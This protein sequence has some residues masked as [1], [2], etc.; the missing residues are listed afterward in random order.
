MVLLGETRNINDKSTYLIKINIKV[1]SVKHLLI[2]IHPKIMSL[3]GKVPRNK[4]PMPE[5]VRSQ[6]LKARM[7]TLE[8]LLV[9]INWL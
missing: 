3:N 6:E 8:N 9:R 1:E 4:F 5:N 2:G 7:H